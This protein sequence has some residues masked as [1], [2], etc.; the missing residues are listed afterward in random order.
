M[1][2]FFD[3]AL[4]YLMSTLSG[5]KGAGKAPTP[6]PQWPGRAHPPPSRL[7]A[8][9][10]SPAPGARTVTLTPGTTYRALLQLGPATS[11][12]GND[13]VVERLQAIAGPFAN[14]KATGSGTDRVATGR[15]TGK[16]RTINLP[17]EVLTLA[18]IDAKR[19]AAPAPPRDAAPPPPAAVNVPPVPERAPAPSASG[20]T[21]IRAAQELHDYAR[22]AIANRQGALLGTKTRPNAFVRGAQLDMGVTPADGIYGPATRTRGQ[23]LL[24]KSFPARVSGEDRPMYIP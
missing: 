11:W 21:P 23:Q 15:Y 17:P 2:P 14:A 24:R 5:G 18:A 13:L 20:R 10:P 8:P 1:I 22:K 3:L 12:A 7:P 9:A 6:E 16:A 19:D 4:L